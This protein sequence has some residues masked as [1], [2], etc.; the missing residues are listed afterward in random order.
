MKNIDLNTA[1]REDLMEIEGIDFVLADNIIGYRE[2]HGGIGSV[3]ELRDLSGISDSTLDELRAATG[4]GDESERD[5]DVGDV[6]E[7]DEGEEW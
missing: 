6:G 2:E 3:D 7:S 1:S 5:F 4:E